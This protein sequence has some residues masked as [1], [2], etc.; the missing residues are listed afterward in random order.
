MKR[1]TKVILVGLSALDTYT[2][3]V[4]QFMIE[5]KTGNIRLVAC[6]LSSNKLYIKPLIPDPTKFN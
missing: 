2:Q 3:H 4:L 6:L 5:N 1:I